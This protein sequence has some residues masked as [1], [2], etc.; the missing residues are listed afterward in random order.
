MVREREQEDQKSEV[1]PGLLHS[2]FQASLDYTR[3]YLKIK[4]KS[5]RH[6]QNTRPQQNDVKSVTS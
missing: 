3:P 4:A 1:S 5:S 2:D 6:K